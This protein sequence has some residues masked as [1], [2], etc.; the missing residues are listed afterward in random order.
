MVALAVVVGPGGGRQGLAWRTPGR[1]GP[2]G[3]GRVPARRG[4]SPGRRGRRPAGTEGTSPGSTCRRRG[5]ASAAGSTST[6]GE[7]PPWPTAS[8]TT[9]TRTTRPGTGWYRVRRA[10]PLR[11]AGTGGPRARHA[12]GRSAGDGRWLVSVEE[13]VDR[14][15][16]HAPRGGHAHRRVGPGRGAGRGRPF[17][18]RAP[19]VAGRPVAGLVHVGPPDMPWDA[20]T[21]R[22][23]RAVG[24]RR[25]PR[26]R[27][28]P[29]PWPAARACRWASP[30]GRPTAPCS[31][32][33]TG[34]AGGCPTAWRRTGSAARRPGAGRAGRRRR[35][36]P[37]AGLGVRPADLRPNWPTDPWWPAWAR[38]VV[39]DW[40]SCAPPA[41]GPDAGGWTIV[42]IDQPCVS[43]AGVVSPDGVSAVVLGTT[44]TEADVVL[45]VALDGSASG[46]APVGTARG[47]WCRRTGRPG[48][49]PGVADTPTHVVPGLFFAPTNPDVTPGSRVAPAPGGVLPRRAD[50]RRR[51]R[52]R[53]R[54]PVPHQ[55]GHRRGGRRLPGEHRVR[56]GLPGRAAGRVGRGRRRRLRGIRPV[57]G[58]RRVWSTADGWPSAAPAPAG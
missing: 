4:G 11:L 54:G 6:A 17:R 18:G 19:T 20:T 22:V 14:H 36:V 38:V 40:W 56:P 27:A 51:A 29:A 45:A 39:T 21:L 24:D 52:L 33:T 49:R 48:P 23:A 7:R 8:C 30:A 34:P 32:W 43:L 13:R 46:P 53:P 15:D 2:C 35:R 28:R 3:V 37:R 44:A 26:P 9:W 10:A 12:D 31:S 58:R 55:P 42:E 1:R 25:R 5:P 47:W 16:G 57:A 41:A 50:R